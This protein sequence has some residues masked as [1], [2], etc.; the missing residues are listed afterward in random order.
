M[1]LSI[2]LIMYVF[3]K[4][5]HDFQ[6]KLFQILLLVTFAMLFLEIVYVNTMNHMDKIPIINEVICRL[7]LTFIIIWMVMFFIYIITIGLN[8]KAAEKLEK[9]SIKVPYLIAALCTVLAIIDSFFKIDYLIDDGQY[10]IVG[11]ATYFV[12]GVVGILLIILLVYIIKNKS[13]YNSSLRLPL[14]FS[15]VL[16]TFDTARLFIFEI[17]DLTLM[18]ALVVSSLYF[19]VESQDRLLLKEVGDAK[20]KS[21]EV[22]KAKTE[23]LA[24]M[25]HEIRTPMNTILGFSNAL[26]MEEN[27]S[28]EKVLEEAK[29]IN[30]ASVNLLDLINNILE[31]SRIESGSET[32]NE[33]EY[34]LEDIISEAKNILDSK[35]A[36]KDSYYDLEI[37][38][39]IPTS[40]LGD[41]SKVSKIVNSIIINALKYTTDGYIN[42]SINYKQ[43][44]DKEYLI[45]IVSNSGDKMPQEYYNRDFSDFSKLDYGNDSKL[46]SEFLG[47]IIAK[48]LISMFE[49]STLEFSKEQNKLT[50]CVISLCQKSVDKTNIDK[51]VLDNKK[52]Q[53]I[54]CSGKKALIVDDNDINLKL[55]EKLL[56]NYNF[57]ITK[58]TSGNECINLVKINDYD[59]IFLDHMMPDM[60]GLKTIE[61]IKSIK[62]GPILIVAMTANSNTDSDAFYKEKGFDAYIGKPI[63]KKQLDA[64][65]ER[66]FGG[67][68]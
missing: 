58:A 7:F 6:N 17:N 62:K 23:F 50:K 31:L 63:N 64:L 3:K 67:E 33:K 49:D 5:Y 30:L 29:S 52:A 42:F 19:T 16:I 43:D 26:L 38:D 56:K 60:D 55:T 14:Y 32:V 36:G 22:D 13:N 41:F 20:T 12:Y 10:A 24:K 40:F 68:L 46:D 35:I 25:S 21:E 65:I 47:V 51:S 1:F 54:D 37:N 15:L 28:R 18:L 34:K 45:F 2:T 8:K 9:T 66:L 4:K 27:V 57:N 48:R 11:P 44:N 39:N 61:V 59:V 53:I